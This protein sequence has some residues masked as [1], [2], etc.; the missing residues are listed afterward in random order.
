MLILITGGAKN[1]K[2]HHAERVFEQRELSKVYLATMEPYGEEAQQAIRRHQ[3][4]RAQKG[5]RTIEKYRDIQDAELPWGCGV[6]IECMATLCANEMF[7]HEE[8]ADPVDKIIEA[9]S[10]ICLRAQLVVIVT[11][12]VGS[13]G[14]AYEKG[15]ALYVRLLGELNRRL[16][17]KADTVI[18]CVCGIPLLLKGEWPWVC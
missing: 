18:E 2:S 13:D 1:G 8:P 12:D 5:F 10:R 9:V 11:N 6:L 3:H 4:I 16:A 14:I 7:A 15:T 17:E